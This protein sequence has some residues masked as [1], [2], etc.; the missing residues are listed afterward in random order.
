MFFKGHETVMMC[1]KCYGLIKDK[2]GVIYLKYNDDIKLC[3]CKEKHRASAIN[4]DKNIFNVVQLLNLK[5][6]YTSGSCEG[7]G[8]KGMEVAFED[9]NKN[10]KISKKGL[11]KGFN[12]CRG[13]IYSTKLDY[14]S[15][16]EKRE[17]NKELLEWIKNLKDIKEG[18]DK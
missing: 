7:K 1:D 4:I 9:L 15:P 5:G 17:H 18:D 8:H 13:G 10:V 12:I 16:K 3:D 14:N 11:P 6:Y 2:L